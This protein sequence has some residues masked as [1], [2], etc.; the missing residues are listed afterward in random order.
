MVRESVYMETWTQSSEEW[1][2]T[3]G[4]NVL[5]GLATN[6]QTLPDSYFEPYISTI[7]GKIHG[8]KNRIRHAM[9][10]ALIAIGTRN[11]ALEQ[12]AIAAATR[13]GKV[14]VDHGETNCKTPDAVAYIKKVNDRQAESA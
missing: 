1:I 14:I 8:S 5:A 10:S 13:I 4:W 11:P 9:N 2:G 3:L 12:K 6:D 7:D